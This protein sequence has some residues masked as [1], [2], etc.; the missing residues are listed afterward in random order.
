VPFPAPASKTPAA[1]AGAPFTHVVA[2]LAGVA[3]SQLRD[4]TLLKG[5]LIA[6]AG[7]AGFATVGTP[8]VYTLPNESVAAVLMLDGCH[9]ALHS[10]PERE[11]LLLDVLSVSTHDPWK[12]VEVFARRLAPREVRHETLPRG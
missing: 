1:T 3:A 7:G 10:F 11:L 6:A 12:A 4:A 5:L 9:I 2:D 8:L